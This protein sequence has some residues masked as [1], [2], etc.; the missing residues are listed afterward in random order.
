MVGEETGRSGPS[1]CTGKR[2]RSDALVE[3]PRKRGKLTEGGIR[4]VSLFCGAGGLDLGFSMSGFTL[5]AAIDKDADAVAS[6]ARNIGDHVRLQDVRS[7]HGDDL[8]QCDVLIGGP[9][10]YVPDFFTLSWL[11]HAVKDFRWREKWTGG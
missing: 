6:Y 11:I 10:W 7:V 4:T 8:P 3:S 2:A 1:T 9:P 5:V